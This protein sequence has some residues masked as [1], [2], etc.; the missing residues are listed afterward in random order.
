MTSLDLCMLHGQLHICS[1]ECWPQLMVLLMLSHYDDVTAEEFSFK[2]FSLIKKLW[3]FN[4]LSQAASNFNKIVVADVLAISSSLI[5][6]MH[7]FLSH[8]I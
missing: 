4:Y 1:L 5:N 7:A 3:F 6:G 2:L 8:C